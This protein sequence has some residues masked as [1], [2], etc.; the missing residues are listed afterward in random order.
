MK[1]FPFNDDELLRL[2]DS[3][4]TPCFAYRGESAAIQYRT[5]DRARGGATVQAA[6]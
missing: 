4:G 1:L 6:T 2:A 5:L 3:Q